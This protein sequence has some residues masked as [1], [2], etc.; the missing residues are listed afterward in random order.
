MLRM[1]SCFS[2][3]TSNRMSSVLT[4]FRSCPISCYRSWATFL[5]MDAISLESTCCLQNFVST[6]SGMRPNI[7]ACVIPDLII[8]SVYRDAYSATILVVSRRHVYQ[9][10]RPV[11]K[12]VRPVSRLLYPYRRGIAR[13]F[14]GDYMSVPRSY[15]FCLWKRK[16]MFGFPVAI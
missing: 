3:R 12:T 16:P 2:G 15:P 9:S 14:R 10:F 8:V 6:S 1:S 13:Y 7:S 11:W 5:L 4:Y